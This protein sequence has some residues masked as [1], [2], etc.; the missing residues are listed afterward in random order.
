MMSWNE[1]V[2]ALSRSCLND[3]GDV[4]V[5]N[6]ADNVITKWRLRD[7]QDLNVLT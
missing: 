6:T 2:G 7:M 3:C 5:Y 1:V 4:D